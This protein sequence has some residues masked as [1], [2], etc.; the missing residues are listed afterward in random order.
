MHNYSAINSP[1]P[2]DILGNGLLFVSNLKGAELYSDDYDLVLNCT[3]YTAFFSKREDQKRIRIPVDDNP[4]EAVDLIAILKDNYIIELIALMIERN[5]KVLI[6]CLAGAQ[7]SPAVAACFLVAR[8]G[9][10]VEH[11]IQ[12][13]RNRRQA[14]FFLGFV[15]FQK[16]IDW[17]VEMRP[18]STP[19]I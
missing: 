10:T 4:D 5:K 9:F 13:V 17:S 15:T 19:N 12:E 8:R 2:S 7:R 18:K 16:T 3:K 6:H 14:A 1:E 11:A